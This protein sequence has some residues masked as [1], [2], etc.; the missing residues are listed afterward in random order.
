[1]NRNRV[2]PILTIDGNRLVKTVK[3]KNPKYIGDPINAIKI[4]NDKEV[5]EIIVLD[6][7]ASK[8]KISPNFK[9]IKEMASECFMPLGYGGGINN[10]DTAKK[11]FDL[12]VEKIIM[13]TTIY[14]NAKLIKEISRQYGN[15]SVVVSLDI[16]KNIFG[17]EYCYYRSGSITNKEKVK[18]VAVNI[19]KIGAGEIILNY[20]D[21]EGTFKGYNL[22]LLN[23]IS[24]LVN[25]PVVPCG[26]AKGI[27][28]FILAKKNGAS[29]MAASSIFIYKSNNTNSILINY[30]TQTE[31]EEKLYNI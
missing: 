25:I 24:S 8:K 29:A 5:D 1:M 17:N 26:G 16:K 21:R 22:E 19:E 15:Q 18:D 28:D 4:F 11:I 12:G 9:L 30:P 20:V 7:T 31:L 27:E 13:N 10:I 23:T 3:F 6:I 14:N 2:I